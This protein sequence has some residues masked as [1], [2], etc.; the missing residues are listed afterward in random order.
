MTADTA[1]GRVTIDRLNSLY[2]FSKEHPAPDALRGRLDAVMRDRLSAAC[3]RVLS[4][5]LDATD[6]SVWLIRRLD[7]DLTLDAGAANDDRIAQAWGNC[8]ATGIVRMLARGADGDAV[9]HFAD[10]AAYLAQFAGDLAGDR[11]WDQWC[12]AA[13][14]SLRSLPVSAALREALIRD[15]DQTEPALLRLRA[16]GRL[17]A[18]L[19]ALNGDDAQR[20]YIAC[21]LNGSTGPAGRADVE[22]V[23][24]AWQMARPRAGS[25]GFVTAHNRLRL[26]T[27]IRSQPGAAYNGLGDAID[28]VLGF[29]EVLRQAE[30]TGALVTRLT[31]GDPRG[32]IALARSGGVTSNLESLAAMQRLVDGDSL[33]R[34]AHVLAPA[35]D[36]ELTGSEPPSTGQAFIT[37]F[38]GIFLLL[39][40]MQDLGVCNWPE[41]NQAA[42]LRYW[43][44]L[45]CFGRARARE[46]MADSVMRLAVGLQ[47]TP[48]AE[49]WQAL[50]GSTSA[51]GEACLRP[52]IENLA[53]RGWIEGRALCAEEVIGVWPDRSIL[54]VSDVARDVWLYAA[55]I[56]D[57]TGLRDALACAID[58]VRQATGISASCLLIASALARRVE[59]SGLA[60]L[61]AQI[62]TFDDETRDRSMLSEDIRAVVDRCFERRKSAAIDLRYLSWSG[63]DLPFGVHPDF[64]LAGSIVARAVLKGFAARLM[65]FERSSAEYL[66]R[67]FLE[68]MSSVRVAADRI[69]VALP[70]SPLSVIL[71]MA[72]L[73]GESYLASWLGDIQVML[74]LS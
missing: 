3:G 71:H 50:M 40:A 72:G 21:L 12:Y 66:H 15:S 34:V 23:V 36:R 46:A 54:L 47:E 52:S 24:A 38:G 68:G 6:P 19:N 20:V 32:A 42:M 29:A 28:R 74:S 60:G 73:D 48:P 11:A 18:V 69:E 33:A 62:V 37:P 22:A 67:N 27:T 31:E 10:R 26:Y 70:S 57:A 16:A 5:A 49:D 1:T 35:P 58:W 56:D 9:L 41:Q 13:F 2:L 61:A 8:L 39:R 45:K 53:Q 59:A 17:E 4:E 64:D 63:A 65:G 14:D 51:L 43:I 30:S 44:A 55:P 7:I 25:I